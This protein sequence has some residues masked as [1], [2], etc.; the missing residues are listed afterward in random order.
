MGTGIDSSIHCG[1]YS[2]IGGVGE[3]EAV[4]R[5]GGGRGGGGE[6]SGGSSGGNAAIQKGG[7][8][9]SYFSI[10]FHSLFPF[11]TRSSYYSDLLCFCSHIIE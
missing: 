7:T 8:C 1:R 10:L 6:D 2:R 5:M 11:L 3:G 9:Q 4:P